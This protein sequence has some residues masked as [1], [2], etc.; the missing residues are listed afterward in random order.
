MKGLLS[1]AAAAALLA[2]AAPSRAQPTAGLKL[3]GSGSHLPATDKDFLTVDDRLGAYLGVFAEVPLNARLSAQ[4]DLLFSQKGGDGG[5]SI[6]GTD[7]LTGLDIQSDDWV[8]T[9]IDYLELPCVLQINLPE[10]ER[11]VVKLSAGPY[12]ALLLSAKQ[13]VA[14]SAA[15]FSSARV[16]T[17]VRGAE[18][19]AKFDFGY[20]LGF[21]VSLLGV[22]LT[23]RYLHG[24]KDVMP[25]SSADFTRYLNPKNRTFAGAVEIPLF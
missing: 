3:G 25:G 15:T 10:T 7:S 5:R 13:T 20:C 19:F 2:L 14:S 8:E 9:R 24:I 17:Y 4:A 23:G 6:S 1:L 22:R 18:D 12:L 21:S 11:A 16:T